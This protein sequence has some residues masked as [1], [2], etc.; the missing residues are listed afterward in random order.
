M[1]AATIDVGDRLELFV[2]HHVIDRLEGTALKLHAPLPAGEAVRFDNPWEG[3]FSTYVT[4][5]ADGGTYRMYYRGSSSSAGDDRDHQV[6]CYAESADGKRWIKPHLGLHTVRGTRENN[7][8]LAGN[9]PLSHNFSPFVDARPDV[10]AAERFKA[11]GGTQSTGLVALCSGDGV[12]WR[13]WRREPVMPS[14]PDDYRY[15]SQNLAFW[16]QHEGC[17]LCYFRAWLGGAPEGYRTIARSQSADFIHW[18]A[19]KLMSFGDRPPEHLYTSQTHPYFRAPH[20]YLALPARFLPGR[21]ALSTE[22]ARRME[23]P[24]EYRKD[25]SETVL[26]TSRGG[27]RFDRSFMEAFIRPGL[28]RGDWVSRSNYAALGVVP[29]GPAEL[30]LYVVRHYAQRSIYLERQTL[31]TDG[32]ISVNSPYTGGTMVTKTIRFAGGELV[33]NYATGANG[34]VSV[35]LQDAAG[36]ALPGFTEDQCR[37]LFGDQIERVVRWTGGSSVAGLAGKPIRVRFTMKDADLY[38]M[39][40]R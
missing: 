8:V 14:D 11:L 18:S 17:Y 7:V 35:E 5:V 32:F 3:P 23:V 4:V 15:D 10:P 24:Q 31:R 19:P 2:D 28:E 33:L 13:H 21:Q 6:T 27:E 1:A 30:S 34:Q 37:V 16:S 39:R 29:T 12:H 36:R 20:I 38:A 40:F 25:C 26:M 22:E 9:G